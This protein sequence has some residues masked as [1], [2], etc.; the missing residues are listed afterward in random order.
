MKTTKSNAEIQTKEALNH[1]NIMI[2]KQSVKIQ[3]AQYLSDMVVKILSKC[4]E[5]RL[6]RDRWRLR[7]ETA[8]KKL[9]NG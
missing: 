4:E 6:S 5:L 9:K 7:A 2:S 1:I 3:D 8:E